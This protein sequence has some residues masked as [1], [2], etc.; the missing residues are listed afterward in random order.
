MLCLWLQEHAAI[1]AALG[2]KPAGGAG[3]GGLGRTFTPEVNILQELQLVEERIAGHYFGMVLCIHETPIPSSGS[4]AVYLL[5]LQH[6]Y[7]CMDPG[8]VHQ[9]SSLRCVS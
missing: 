5:I 4:L 7:A 1:S 3:V 9:L 8:R 6:S 2:L